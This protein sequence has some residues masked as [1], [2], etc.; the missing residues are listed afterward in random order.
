[1]KYLDVYWSDLF[2]KSD[3]LTRE[4]TRELR[5]DCRTWFGGHEWEVAALLHGPLTKIVADAEILD[6]YGTD[7]LVNG[8]V[9]ASA[10]RG[11]FRA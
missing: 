5:G 10:S 1:M 7:I 2:K 11:R 3:S 6:K 8:S 9:E 4:I